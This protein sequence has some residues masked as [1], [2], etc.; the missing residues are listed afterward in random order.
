MKHSGMQLSSSRDYTPCWKPFWSVRKIEVRSLPY[1]GRRVTIWLW[2][3]YLPPRFEPRATT[4]CWPRPNAGWSS[5]NRRTTPGFSPP[6]LK[7]V[8]VAAWPATER[9][10]ANCWKP[11]H[12]SIPVLPGRC[13]P[14]VI[15]RRRSGGGGG[16]STPTWIRRDA[17]GRAAVHPLRRAET[18]VR[19]QRGHRSQGDRRPNCEMFVVPPLGGSASH[20][21]A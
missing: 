15:L 18:T 11:S 14:L 2:D 19:V 17:R 9:W 3:E 10:L 7:S 5:R 20:Q 1:V 12:G 13:W 6:T 4:Q 16:N 8:P 21:T